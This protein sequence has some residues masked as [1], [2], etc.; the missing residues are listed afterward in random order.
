MAN[1]GCILLSLR[2]K[3]F[4]PCSLA[5]LSHRPLSLQAESW[6]RSCFHVCYRR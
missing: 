3:N 4:K 2:Q 6:F 5:G 1:Q